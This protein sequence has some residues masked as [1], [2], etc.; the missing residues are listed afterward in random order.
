VK[1]KKCGRIVEADIRSLANRCMQG[2]AQ[3]YPTD[4]I[5]HQDAFCECATLMRNCISSPRSPEALVV[6]RAIH[7]VWPATGHENREMILAAMATLLDMLAHSQHIT[8]ARFTAVG[9]FL[10]ALS[11]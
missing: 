8:K 3:R 11:Q 9:K 10:A 7:A 4:R 1:P 6:G 5:R 2:M